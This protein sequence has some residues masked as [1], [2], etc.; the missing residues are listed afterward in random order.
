MIGDMLS[1]EKHD[2]VLLQ[3]VWRNFLTHNEDQPDCKKKIM[4]RFLFFRFG[5]RKIISF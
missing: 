2:I 3:E 4:Q 5:A 1:K